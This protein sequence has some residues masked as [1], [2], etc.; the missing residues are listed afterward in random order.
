MDC[1]HSPQAKGRL[2]RFFGTAQERLVKGLRKT[3]ARTV[4]DGNRYLAQ[5]YLPLWNSRFTMKPAKGGDAHR[6]LPGG[7]RSGSHLESC[8]GAGGGQRL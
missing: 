4:A 5:V 1:P 7:A 3:A 6:P 2:E 8:G